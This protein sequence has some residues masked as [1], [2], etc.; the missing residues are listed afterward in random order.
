MAATGQE[1]FPCLAYSHFF[2]YTLSNTNTEHTFKISGEQDEWKLLNIILENCL[3]DCHTTVTLTKSLNDMRSP[4]IGSVPRLQYIFKKLE[5]NM[6]ISC[7]VA[8][9]HRGPSITH[10][11]LWRSD[12]QGYP[13]SGSHMY[14]IICIQT[15]EIIVS[16]SNSAHWPFNSLRRG[17]QF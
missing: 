14:I 15:L 12:L 3:G 7:L 16:R 1:Y 9:A 5:R 10:S 4:H 13:L 11:L 6:R 17:K 2:S 8:I